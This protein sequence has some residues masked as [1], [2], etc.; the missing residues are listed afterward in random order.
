MRIELSV[1]NLAFTVVLGQLL[2]QSIISVIS[3]YKEKVAL[4]F[5]GNVPE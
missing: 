2:N 5:M 1:E 4:S 3:F